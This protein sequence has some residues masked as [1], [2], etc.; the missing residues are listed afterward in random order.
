MTPD[1]AGCR[2]RLPAG[3]R[4]WGL[5]AQLYLLRSADELGH[6]R[7][8]RSC[9]NSS[10]SCAGSGADVI[11]LNPLHALFGDAPGACQPVFSGQPAAAQCVE[12]RCRSRCRS[13][14]TRPEARAADGVRVDFQ[15]RLRHAGAQLGRL[16]DASRNSSSRPV[17]SCS[18]PCR[19][20]PDQSRW[21]AIRGLSARGAARCWSRAACF[22]PCASI[23]RGKPDA[24]TGMPGRREFQDAGSEAVARFASEH[25]ERVELSCL[26]AMDR[27][28]ATGRPRRARRGGGMRIGLYRDLAVGADRGGAETWVNPRAVVSR[29]ARRSAAGYLAI[30]PARIGACRRSIR[31]RCARR[32]TV[33]SSNSFAP[34]CACAGGLRID[35]VMALQQ[36]YWI[37]ED[38]TPREGAYV[39]Y[40]LE[41]LVGILALE[42]H[43]HRLPGGRGGPGHRPGEF[44]RAHGGAGIV[45]YRVLFFEQE[46]ATGPLSAAAGYPSLALAV[47]G[48]H[49]LA[50]LR[51]WWLGRDLE[52]KERLG[53]YSRPE[54]AAGQRRERGR[55]RTCLLEALRSAQLWRGEEEPDLEALVAAVHRFLART[56]TCLAM[57]QVDDLSGEL[58]S[59]NVPATCNEH[60]NWRRRLSL[61]LE[62]LAQSRHFHEIT[63][64]FRDERPAT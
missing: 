27:R 31:T 23:S 54:E 8:Y 56:N 61:S 37:P 21:R 17:R 9:S 1:V 4:L 45:S 47:A 20:A 11:G 24:P 16:Y 26:D 10:R 49:D 13:Y 2:R 43:R 48:N 3:A 58:D 55:Q 32:A 42:S 51:G 19:R 40:P 35:H 39:R 50:T 22:W 14:R 44:P 62:E 34:T 38:G 63:Q 52:V 59:I 41:D 25:R 29:R 5:A 46:A 6:R 60:P 18:T 28:G 53:L 30:L 36:L 57:A 12:H 64:I 15:Q 7:F 33:A